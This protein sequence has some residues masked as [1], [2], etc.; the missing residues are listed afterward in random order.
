[1]GNDRRPFSTARERFAYGS[2]LGSAY[3][4]QG[5]QDK[6]GVSLDD[7]QQ[8]SQQI[9][10]VRV[11]SRAIDDALQDS[12]LESLTQLLRQFSE[13][14]KQKQEKLEV[15]SNLEPGL[16]HLLALAALYLKVEE[17]RPIALVIEQTD[18]ATI[19]QDQEIREQADR[20]LQSNTKNRPNA[21]KVWID[22]GDELNLDSEQRI[23]R[24]K[25][26][27]SSSSNTQSLQQFDRT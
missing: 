15:Y 3:T 4:L 18:N 24:V 16:N 7:A 5:L 1:M 23:L 13:E 27:I 9:M 14:A 10:E 2:D 12:V 6:L 8:R 20:I 26:Q 11:V 25:P 19:P 21:E 17:E 22:Y